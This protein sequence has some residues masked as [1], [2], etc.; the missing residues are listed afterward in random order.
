MDEQQSLLESKLLK[1]LQID[2]AMTEEQFLETFKNYGDDHITK[3]LFELK[4]KGLIEIVLD[5]TETVYV[6]RMKQEVYH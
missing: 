6:I 3:A 2:I 1:K 4:V 5:P